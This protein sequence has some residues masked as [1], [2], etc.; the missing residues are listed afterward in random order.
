MTDRLVVPARFNGPPGSGNG[1]VVSGLLA[2]A[3]GGPGAVTVTLRRPPPLDLPLDLHRDGDALV[4]SADGAVVASAEP[5]GLAHDPVPPVSAAEARTAE[6]RYAGLR[7]HPFPTCFVCG[8]GRGD[9]M[10]LRPG[11]VDDGSARVACAWVPDAS[12]PRDGAV[13]AAAMVWAALDC[14]SGWASDIEH[15]PM[16][17]GRMTAVVAARPSVGEPC[18]VVARELGAEGRRATTASTAYGADGRLLGRAEAVWIA[19]RS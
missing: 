5:G 12:L 15:R 16:V 9:G 13:V 4:A 18:V 1:G 3:F 10:H 7:S 6:P 2:G 11:R 17:L 8:P 19:L 14:P